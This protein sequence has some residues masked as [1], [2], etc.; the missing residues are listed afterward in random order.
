M[1]TIEKYEAMEGDEEKDKGEKGRVGW[2][3]LDLSK[4]FTP[5]SPL[6]FP[7]TPK[8]SPPFLSPSL[9]IVPHLWGI[10]QQFL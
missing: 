8:T 10:Y 9:S 7:N 4:V 1:N 6:Q 5:Q 3:Q 2:D